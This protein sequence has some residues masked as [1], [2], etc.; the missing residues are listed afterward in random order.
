V[1]RVLLVLA[2]VLLASCERTPA[3]PAAPPPQATTVPVL[4][5]DNL[6][7]L[8]FGAAVVERRD[9]LSY[10]SSVAHALDGTLMTDWTSAPGGKLVATISLAAPTRL[11]RLGVTV[12]PTASHAPKAVRFETSLDGT[13]WRTALERDLQADTVKPQLFDITPVDARYLRVTGIDTDYYSSF[14]SLYASGAETAPFV[15]PPLE[16]CWEINAT[17]PARFERSGARV[18]GTIG[19]IV[20][21]GGTDGR[22]YRL[23]WREGMTWGHAAVS[24]TPDGRHLSGVRWYEEVNQ[25]H[26]GD[27]WL[28]KRVPC[29]AAAPIDG[30]AI[31]DFLIRR[32]AMW[33]LYGVRFDRQDRILETESANALDLAAKLVREHPKHRFRLIGREFRES[34]VGKNRARATAKLNATREALGKR[35]AD[36][37]RIELISDGSDRAP[38]GADFTTQRVMDTG[39]EL[40]V[41]PL[42]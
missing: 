5:N 10:E 22:V 25:S 20:I 11:R 26:S 40:L 15:Q 39:V 38:L 41:L 32:A 31:V 17:V 34:S 18:S 27:G 23:M 1:K 19:N 36:L 8:V 37:S 16:G 4:E 6:L 13:T 35:G 30:D 33:R 42:R 9:E 12:P 7:N 14:L 21:D 2:L 24:V 28:G 29:S 3:P